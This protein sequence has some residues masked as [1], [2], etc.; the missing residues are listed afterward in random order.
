[1]QIAGFIASSLPTVTSSPGNFLP[2]QLGGAVSSPA[3][4]IN[5]TRVNNVSNHSTTN[6]QF[7]FTMQTLRSGE[8]VE[9]DVALAR[10]RA[11]I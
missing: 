5:T 6:N 2:M 8:S 11:G 3:T 7:D 10:A 1:M 9:Q 4:S